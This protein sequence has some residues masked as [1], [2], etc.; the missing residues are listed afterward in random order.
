M[1]GA[2]AAAAPEAPEAPE[3]PPKK[4][5]KAAPERGTGLGSRRALTSLD[6]W[7]REPLKHAWSLPDGMAYVGPADTD[8]LRQGRE[9]RHWLIS[10]NA[11][12]VAA[13]ELLT[14][15]QGRK[16][17]EGWQ[18]TGTSEDPPYV[19]PQ[20]QYCQL[21]R[22]R[23]NTNAS[24]A[25]KRKEQR[26]S[27][28]AATRCTGRKFMC[29]ADMGVVMEQLRAWRAASPVATLQ[30][31]TV[32]DIVVAVVRRR[33][34]EE[35]SRAANA[36]VA[37]SERGDTTTMTTGKLNGKVLLGAGFLANLRRACPKRTPA[38]AAL[39]ATAAAAAKAAGEAA[40]AKAAEDRN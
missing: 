29:E 27:A 14:T 15:G 26:E 32:I 34:K 4:K 3:A 22:A 6:A 1:G 11:R 7:E 21:Q 30:L 18:P 35:R 24:R 13:M 12:S 37:A 39:V 28:A 31:P 40:T 8:A 2:Q 38:T 23:G 17:P 5:A 19:W 16:R 36:L 20:L 9:A 10:T 25:Q 33:A